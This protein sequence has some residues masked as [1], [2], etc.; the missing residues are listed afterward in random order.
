M[1]YAHSPDD[2]DILA[3][4]GHED[5]SSGAKEAVFGALA[6]GLGAPCRTDDGNPVLLEACPVAFSPLRVRRRPAANLQDDVLGDGHGRLGKAGASEFLDDPVGAA[7]R[8]S[9]RGPRDRIDVAADLC[10]V[11]LHGGLG[12]ALSVNRGR[13]FVCVSSR[14]RRRG[15]GK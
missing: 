13:A 11:M 15:A 3:R 1:V 7:G 4:A 6:L 10:G 5:I 14:T 8:I 2:V 12:R 9:S